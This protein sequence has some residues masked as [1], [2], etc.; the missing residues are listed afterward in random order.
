M[1]LNQHV[2][3]IN[4]YQFL[5]IF[6]SYIRVYNGNRSFVCIYSIFFSVY[7]DVIIYYCT[8]L[9]HFENINVLLCCS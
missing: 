7:C 8:L 1:A 2:D 9:Y 6:S 4:P 3:S 5:L